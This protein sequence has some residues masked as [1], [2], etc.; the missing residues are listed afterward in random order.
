MTTIDTLKNVLR[1]QIVDSGIS[2][3]EQPLN[4]TEYGNG[5]E[6]FA[7]GSSSSVY[8]DF[9]IPQLIQQTSSL[10][11]SRTSI[12]VLEIGPGP[13]SILGGLPLEMRQKVRRY[14]SFEP[15]KLFAAKLRSWLS[16]SDDKPLP[17]LKDTGDIHCIPFDPSNITVDG[18]RII[19][20]DKDSDKYDLVLFCH[21]LY[22]M[23]PKWKFV[24]MALQLLGSVGSEM[25][26]VFHRDVAL[27]FEGLVCHQTL[28]HASGT[29]RVSLLLCAS[30][31]G[32][33]R[34]SRDLAT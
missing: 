8:N 12:S 2:G 25:V 10:F 3:L 5:F 18:A 14:T 16:D 23:S 24:K 11:N 4:D 13:Q 15:N 17:N 21:N 27:D 32:H 31:D 20:V 7:R 33:I 19:D 29:C 6:I 28:S 34:S 26:V 9:I 22:G 1:Q 30:M